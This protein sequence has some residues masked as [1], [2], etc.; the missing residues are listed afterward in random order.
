MYI[1]KLELNQLEKL[2][3]ML[4]GT[5]IS[6]EMTEQGLRIILFAGEEGVYPTFYLT[7]FVCIPTKFCKPL[8]EKVN[9][10]YVEFMAEEF[11]DFLDNLNQELRKTGFL[12]DD[13]KNEFIN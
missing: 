13:N 3:N 12:K 7:D 1:E 11:D 4:G 8:I 5:F 2:A 9:T 10:I 6:G